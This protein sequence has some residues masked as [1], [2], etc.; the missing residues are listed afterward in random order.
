MGGSL[1]DSIFFSTKVE[2]WFVMCH[3]VLW[4]FQ[5]IAGADTSVGKNNAVAYIR[6]KLKG[7]SVAKE[8]FTVSIFQHHNYAR[9][10]NKK[11]Y[12]TIHHPKLIFI[13]TLIIS[14]SF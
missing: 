9:E 3:G 12:T 8:C 7:C 4:R 5:V 6:H 2:L 1:H 13:F 11:H 10:E 14:S